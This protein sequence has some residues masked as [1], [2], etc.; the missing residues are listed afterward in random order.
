M[1]SLP[2]WIKS[3]SLDRPP[4]GRNR[5]ETV[6]VAG[7]YQ[8]RQRLSSATRAIPEDRE[9]NEPEAHRW[10]PGEFAARAV[11]VRGPAGPIRDHAAARGSDRTGR[12]WPVYAVGPGGKRPEVAENLV[13]DL[14]PLD[15]YTDPRQPPQRP[16]G[17][18]ASRQRSPSGGAGSPAVGP[19]PAGCRDGGDESGPRRIGPRW[20]TFGTLHAETG[21]AAGERNAVRPIP[22]SCRPPGGC[23]HPAVECRASPPGVPGPCGASCTRRK[24]SQ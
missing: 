18:A 15:S 2:E 4:T 23:R 10:S 5:T 1:T 12:G 9:A 17:S 6:G 19:S 24:A 16:C 20:M 13:N 22:R 21:P 7:R 3:S 8:R 11:V 14:R